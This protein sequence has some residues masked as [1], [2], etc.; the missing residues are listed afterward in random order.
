MHAWQLVAYGS[1][2]FVMSIFS[3]IAGAG[4]GFIMTPLLI[5]LGLTPA[6]AVSSGKFN[7]LAVAVGSLSGLKNYKGE[8][9][10]R[11]IIFITAASVIVGLIV[12]SIIKSFESRSYRLAMGVILLLII[13]LVMLKR[14]GITP[15]QPSPAN[16]LLGGIFITVSLFLQGIFSGGVGSLVNI[17]L[18]GMFGLKA[19]QAN[20][21]KRWSQ[22]ILNTTIIFGVF[23]SGLIIWQVAAIGISASLIGSYIGGRLALEKG[24]AFVMHIMTF[25]IFVAAIFLIAG[26]V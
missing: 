6:Q 15:H 16:R 5:F 25:L 10:K 24:D 8:I 17:A 22:L 7:G 23:S 12:P 20:I 21:I 4:G 2:G 11:I 9:S 13:P 26:A 18:M 1:V 3:G 19:N 14:L